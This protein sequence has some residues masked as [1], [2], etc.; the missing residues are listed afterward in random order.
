M[1]EEP[2]D[3]NVAK[4]LAGKPTAAMANCASFAEPRANSLFAHPKPLSEPFVGDCVFRVTSFMPD[5]IKV[6]P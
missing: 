1:I 2:P 6:Q 3:R 4:P 5:P